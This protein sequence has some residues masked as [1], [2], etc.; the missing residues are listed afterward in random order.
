MKKILN[1]RNILFILLIEV[2]SGSFVKAAIK[3]EEMNNQATA[4]AESAGLGVNSD[5]SVIL[6]VAIKVVLGFLGVIFLFLTLQAGFKWMTAQ[7][8][9]K[10]VEEAKTSL[11]NAIMGL[12]IVLLAYAITVAVFR[13]L[14]FAT[15]GG[16]GGGGGAI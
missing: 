15:S 1:L 8:N 12:V 13:Y 14:P 10:N 9:E 16:G 11:K 7:G 3:S 4:L 2:L 5:L 6:S